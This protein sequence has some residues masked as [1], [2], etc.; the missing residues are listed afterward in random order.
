MCTL[1][2]NRLKNTDSI[3]DFIRRKKD[4]ISLSLKEENEAF[5]FSGFSLIQL[6]HSA[7]PEMDFS[8]V[9]ISTHFFEKKLA[10]PFV[11]TGM[12]GGWKGSL[13]VNKRIA[14]LCQKKGWIMGAG[15]Q[16]RQISDSDAGQEWQEVRKE[17]PHLILIGNIGLS[18]LIQM[19]L[20]K[21]E[22]LVSSLRA[23]AMVV[24]TN[25]LQEALQPEGTPQFKGG[26]SALCDLCKN[27][28]VPVILKETGCGFSQN[29]LQDLSGI[30]LFAVDLSG[31]GGTHWG[32]IEGN[33]IDKEHFLYGI[34]EVFKDWGISTVDSLLFAEK[35][36]RDYE[37]WAS[38][39]IRNGCDAAKAL[40]LGA[41]RIGLARPI[42]QS[43]LQGDAALERT[44]SRLEYELRVALFCSG[45]NSIEAI[46][47][48]NHVWQ[49]K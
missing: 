48:H 7:L 40:A 23:S 46:K 32:R 39:G 9:D 10:T 22:E 37:I 28:S 30:G 36:N 31:Y 42:I 14:R 43:A 34:A 29:T 6:V 8:E 41:N 1:K 24:H 19:E 25:P 18:Q 12:T 20:S 38:G 44:M 27:L 49:W 3:S 26:L 2:K 4:H 33:R 16:R 47:T 21:V 5:G 35:V 17:C 45:C 15:S 13:E 11:V